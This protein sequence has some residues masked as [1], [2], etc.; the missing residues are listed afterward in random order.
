MA[1]NRRPRGRPPGQAP[2][3]TATE[4]VQ[5]FRTARREQKTRRI[6][7]Y[8]PE[9]LVAGL[10]KRYPDRTLEELVVLGLNKLL[11]E[12]TKPDKLSQ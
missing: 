5:R 8:V 1:E 9:E 12:R 6:D 2:P 4:R 3:K 10:V 11:E 7:C